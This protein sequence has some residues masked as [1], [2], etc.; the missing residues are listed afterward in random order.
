MVYKY[1]KLFQVH[2]MTGLCYN[3]MGKDKEAEKAFLEVLDL[4]PD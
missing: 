3:K 2:L 4:K 1:A